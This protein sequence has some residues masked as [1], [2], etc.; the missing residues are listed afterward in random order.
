M[1]HSLG[2]LAH[3][4]STTKTPGKGS[5]VVKNTEPWPCSGEYKLCSGEYLPKRKKVTLRVKGASSYFLV[6]RGNSRGG[7]TTYLPVS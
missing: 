6:I 4:H 5:M 1:S 2:E 3:F 7:F